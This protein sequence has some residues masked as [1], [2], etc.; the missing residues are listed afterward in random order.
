VDKFCAVMKRGYDKIRARHGCNSQLYNFTL[1]HSINISPCHKQI[2]YRNEMV[3][4]AQ[5]SS[6]YTVSCLKRPP[7]LASLPV[8]CPAAMV[9]ASPSVQ[10]ASRRPSEVSASLPSPVPAQWRFVPSVSSQWSLE[11]TSLQSAV[12][13]TYP[14]RSPC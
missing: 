1:S 12:C 13:P 7:T 4:S 2:T 14:T 5:P 11:W 3:L 8:W 6:T 9:V 10:L